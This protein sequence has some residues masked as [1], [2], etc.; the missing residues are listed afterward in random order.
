MN[1]LFNKIQVYASKV[2]LHSQSM[3]HHKSIKSTSSLGSQT[4]LTKMRVIPIRA[5][6]DNYMYLLIDEATNK[7]ACVDPVNASAIS[8]FASDLGVD[9]KY[10]LT[11]HHHHDHAG[12]N[13]EIASMFPNI[14]ILGGDSRIPS[15][16]KVVS[17][18]ESIKLGALNID[19]LLTPC[20]TKTHICYYV[21]S[22][23]DDDAN[24][25]ASAKEASV[26]RAVFTGDTLFVA[27]CGRFFEG[28]PDQM[29][30]ALNTVLANLPSDTKVYCGHEYTINNLKFALSV[31]PQNSDIKGKLAWAQKK[32]S[33]KEPTVPSSIADEKRTNP[34]MRIQRSAVRKYTGET[35]DIEV[36]T[37]LRHAKNEFQP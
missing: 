2:T 24:M 12:G 3:R 31:E 37:A 27:G 5:L 7:A 1:R 18:G 6:S 15:V 8:S 25:D 19:C 21:T 17:N 14:E 20:H 34:F 16:T 32:I 28:T 29:D 30:H 4:A 35:E 23:P 13:E 26:E 33:K 10:C 11:T 36:M 22:Q 9:L